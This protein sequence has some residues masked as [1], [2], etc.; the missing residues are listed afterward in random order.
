VYSTVVPSHAANMRDI[1]FGNTLNT[2]SNLCVSY[3][4]TG[5]IELCN[6]VDL[7]CTC[8][9]YHTDKQYKVKINSSGG[10]V[11]F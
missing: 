3:L 10:R 7:S 2:V 6:G 8:P 4:S 11:Q 9:A 5:D 1:R